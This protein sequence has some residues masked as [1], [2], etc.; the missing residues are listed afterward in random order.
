VLGGAF[1]TANTILGASVIT[2]PYI[3]KTYGIILGIFFIVTVGF[4]TIFTV[5]L[6][7]LAK[8]KTG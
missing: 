8:D 7:L 4:I 2:I 5:W 3:M 1:N 6:L